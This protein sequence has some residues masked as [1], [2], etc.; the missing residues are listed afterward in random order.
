MT[1]P[2]DFDELMEGVE[3]PEERDR[4]RRVHDL[5]V[6][7]GPPP[8][9]SP[10]LAGAPAAPVEEDEPDTSWLPPRRLGA[11]ILVGAGLLGAA[12]GAGYIAGDRGSDEAP[13]AAPA[14]QPEQVIALR[15][16]DQNNTAGASISLGQKGADGNWPMDL[17]VRGLDQLESGD[18]YTLALTK[19]GKPVVTCGTFNVAPTG[20]TTIRMVA[21]YDLDNFDGWAIT[22]YDQQSHRA[23]VVM[24]EAA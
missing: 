21:A 5:L 24:T 7:A 17:T 15:P 4:L 19:N 22:R 16:P 10:A 23:T 9:L 8:E 1:R 3:S 11:A 13:A 6:T 2:P 12:F 14:D 20:T 18:Y